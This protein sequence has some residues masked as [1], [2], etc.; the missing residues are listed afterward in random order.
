MK[1]HYFAL[2]FLSFLISSTYGEEQKIDKK[3]AASSSYK[4]DQSAAKL[5]KQKTA[6]CRR[7]KDIRRADLPMPPPGP[8]EI[9]PD[10]PPPNL[11]PDIPPPM[12]PNIPSP[13]TIGAKAKKH[14]NQSSSAKMARR[15]KGK[16]SNQ[17][18]D[19]PMPPPQPMPPPPQPTIGSKANKS[20]S[21]S[22]M[23][24]HARRKDKQEKESRMARRKKKAKSGALR[25]L[26]LPPPGR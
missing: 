16:K 11:P 12:P 9:P 15:K 8:P 20:S 10:V 1:F 24:K 3:T 7:K 17:A 14:S 4:Q 13:P 21:D 23:Q 18:R 19:L 22:S 25:D 26:P 5:Q 2:V 6:S